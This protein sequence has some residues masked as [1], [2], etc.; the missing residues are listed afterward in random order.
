MNNYRPEMLLRTGPKVKMKI[1]FMEKTRVLRSPYYKCTQLCD[2]L[3]SVP[4]MSRNMSEFNNNM[5]KVDMSVL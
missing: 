3:Q 5:K 2:K 4:Q 1:A